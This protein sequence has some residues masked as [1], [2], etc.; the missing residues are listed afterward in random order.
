MCKHVP[1]KFRKTKETKRD[2][3]FGRNGCTHN[4]QGEVR[5][6]PTMLNTQSVPVEKIQCEML[7]AKK[8]VR[9]T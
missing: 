4:S 6:I 1:R 7:P 8:L 5:N 2:M 3:S 9:R